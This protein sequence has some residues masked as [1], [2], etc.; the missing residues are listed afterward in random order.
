VVCKHGAS[1]TVLAQMVTTMDLV[2]S[3]MMEMIALMVI[4][5]IAEKRLT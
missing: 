1:V 3:G 4:H 5:R 2:I